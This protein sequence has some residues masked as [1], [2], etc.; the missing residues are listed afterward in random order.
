MGAPL[1]SMAVTVIDGR[2]TQALVGGA[3]SKTIFHHNQV[4][5]EK[6]AAQY[7]VHS[8]KTV[9]LSGGVMQFFFVL[10]RESQHRPQP[11]HNGVPSHP[12]QA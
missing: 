11:Q 12:L 7:E 2:R 8:K 1:L 4:C 5:L 9:F 10:L 3:S 6:Q